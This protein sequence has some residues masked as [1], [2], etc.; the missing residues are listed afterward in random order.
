MKPAKKRS[1]NR[2]HR[3]N[4]IDV[5]RRDVRDKDERDARKQPVTVDPKDLK[6]GEPTWD[7]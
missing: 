5:L 4:L 1:F 3:K 6:T 7:L 2:E